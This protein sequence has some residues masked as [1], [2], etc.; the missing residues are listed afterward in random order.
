SSSGRY[1]IRISG[2]PGKNIG[3]YVVFAHL[4]RVL[5][6]ATFSVALDQTINGEVQQDD[7]Y[8]YTFKAVPGM[9]VLIEVRSRVK[10]KFDPVIEFYGQSGWRLAMADDI[11]ADD[12]DAVLQISL[13]DGIGAYTVQVHGY[14][15]TPGTFTLHVKTE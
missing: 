13:D 12:M 4:V 1:T 10:D 3:T 6:T 9:V 11:S 7:R 2:A 5:P 8:N 14:A 15:M